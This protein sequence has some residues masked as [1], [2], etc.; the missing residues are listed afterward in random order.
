MTIKASGSLSFD[1]IKNEFGF[2]PD[3]KFGNYRISK[4]V[5]QMTNLPLDSGVPQSGPIKFSD[6]Y[7]K[8]Q[9]IIVNLF[10]G[11][12]EISVDAKSKYESNEVVVLGEGPKPTNTSG[13]KVIVHVNKLVNSQKSSNN[14]RVALLTGNWNT[15]TD[16]TI[17]VGTAGSISGTGGNGGAGANAG[18]NAGTVRENGTSAIGV[19]DS[20][21]T[22]NIQNNGLIQTG[23]GGGGGGAGRGESRKSG[24]KSSKWCTSTGGGGGGGLGFPIGA[25]IGGLSPTDA[26]QGTNG[27][28][29]D[30]AT[31]FTGGD[32]GDGG[33]SAAGGGHGGD[34]S[35]V[36]GGAA[37]AR[38]PSGGITGS[39]A[40]ALGGEN[41][42]AI[43][44]TSGSTV[45][46]SGNAIVGR[47]VVGT[48]I[49]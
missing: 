12:P 19:N 33:T 6:F 4:T 35:G 45:N 44:N 11:A 37:A 24:K 20:N 5:G 16:F 9:N 31:Q 1:E 14:K 15:G 40:A 28:A 41:G 38:A 13:K 7:N 21:L 39:I 26:D 48:P 47:Q 30:P 46:I 34:S 17:N 29:G 32:G 49:K 23:F 3:N 36:G 25:G 18:N 10:S 42:Y 43:V 27:T 2:P 22:V 8:K